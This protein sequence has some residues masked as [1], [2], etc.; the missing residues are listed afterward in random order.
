M[1]PKVQKV[2]IQPG[3]ISRA[4]HELSLNARLPDSTELVG[5]N[6]INKHRKTLALGYF[7]RLVWPAGTTVEQLL[8]WYDSAEQVIKFRR[9]GLL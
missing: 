4:L 6:T 5:H 7:N 9:L 8:E 2:K 3:E 1:M